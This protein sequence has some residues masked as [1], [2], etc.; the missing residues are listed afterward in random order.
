[1]LPTVLPGDVVLARMLLHPAAPVPPAQ[2]NAPVGRILLQGCR[3]RGAAW[4]TTSVL[5]KPSLPSRR[6]T[7]PA[8]LISV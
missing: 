6:I 5:R 2:G 4:E 7:R 1:L 3:E 8:L